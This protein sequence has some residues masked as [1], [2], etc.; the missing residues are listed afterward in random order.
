[1]NEALSAGQYRSPPPPPSTI[2][3][4]FQ[5]TIS[6]YIQFTISRASPS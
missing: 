5:C 2:P 4:S 6:R 3:R 1:L